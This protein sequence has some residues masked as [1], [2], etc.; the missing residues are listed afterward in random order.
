MSSTPARRNWFPLL[1]PLMLLGVV[2][3]LICIPLNIV[4]K[5]V[6]SLLTE[7][8]EFGIGWLALLPLIVMPVLLQ[9]QQ[10]LMRDGAGS[11]IPQTVACIEDAERSSALLG[12][13]PLLMRL[14]LWGL[15]ASCLLP[16]GREGPVVFVGASAV[17]LLRRVLKGP[18]KELGVPL[19]L[20]VAGGA[21]L[22]AGFNTPLVAIVFA[23]EDLYKRF[24]LPLVWTALP[25]SLLAALVA[26]FGGEPMFAY[27]ELT[28]LMTAPMQML[29]AMPVGVVGGLVGALF[30]GLMLY[31]TRK[32]TPL[33]RRFPIPM[34][35]LLGG[36]LSLMALGNPRVLGQGSAVLHDLINTG[37]PSSLPEALAVLGE[38]I[39]GPVMV[40][41]SGVPG[42]LI[43]P[44]L[45]MGATVGTIFMP[46]LTG[47]DGV[48]GVVFG[49]AAGLA[50][51][52]QLPIFA[53]LFTLK[54]CGSLQSVPGLLVS[55]GLAAMLSRA[56]QPKP[57]Y[58][59]LAEQFIAGLNPEPHANQSAPR[60]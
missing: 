4:D 27:G 19:L 38:R 48:M 13:R 10:R 30:S 41:G 17:W 53:A 52:T 15:A 21:G 46:L 1:P 54:L 39:I 9:L 33:A 12:L 25:V 24:N 23:A 11:G 14:V 57:V 49:M 60:R 2:V 22:A 43:D 40:L 51:A 36:G 28:A 59:A 45:A 55:A 34:G 29:M 56:L 18:A 37:G 50:G 35:L 58:H 26:A 5:R 3:G 7:G 32:M 20:S 44:A 42:G 47:H 6:D 8:F 16:I 31:A